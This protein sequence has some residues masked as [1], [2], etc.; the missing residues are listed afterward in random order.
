MKIIDSSGKPDYYDFPFGSMID[1]TVVY[2][3]D[4]RQLDP[5]HRA[6][7]L[8]SR[9]GLNVT[10][11]KHPLYQIHQT[12]SYFFRVY[13]FD[14]VSVLL[15]GK[16]YTYARRYLSKTT[17]S[18]PITIE[19]LLDIVRSSSTS[20]MKVYDY[21]KDDTRTLSVDDVCRAIKTY[22]EHLK[23]SDFISL[24]D[25]F[26]SPIITITM[27]YGFYKDGRLKE[28]GFH[29]ILPAAQVFQEISLYLGKQKNKEPKPIANDI[30][31]AKHG[32]DKASF[33]SSRKK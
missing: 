23:G 4:A 31:V 28:I 12:L 3:R 9:L 16:F 19:E 30:V 8:R 5:I 14:V 1:K 2:N 33:R 25:E 24:N 17:Y 7:Y 11:R 21:Q 29:Y 18:N 13:G 27:D 22:D 10:T 15:C 26:K 20:E 6:D 32:F